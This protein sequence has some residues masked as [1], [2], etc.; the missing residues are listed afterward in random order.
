MRKFQ[1]ILVHI[2]AVIYSSHEVFFAHISKSP[3]MKFLFYTVELSYMDKKLDANLNF[4]RDC[5][6]TLEKVLYFVH[7]P[8]THTVFFFF[9]FFNRQAVGLWL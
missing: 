5:L 2:F 9:F 8:P 6:L 1:E 4:C 3:Y 7:S